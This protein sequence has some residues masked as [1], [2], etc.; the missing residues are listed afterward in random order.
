MAIIETHNLAKRYGS[1]WGI[2]DVDLSVEAGSIFGFL[3]PNGAGKTTT[4]R[5]LLGF[6]RPTSGDAH[7]LGKDCWTESASIKRDVGYLAGDVRL[8]SW[9]DARA[10]LDIVGKIR[11]IDLSAA[12]AALLDRFQLDPTVKVRRMSRGMRQKL[13]L[14]LCLAPKPRVLILDEP[15]SGLDPLMQD[16]LYDTLRE[17]AAS[18][19]T[20]LFS[21]HT[22]DEVERLCD[23]IAIVRSGNIVASDSVDALRQHAKRPVVIEFADDVTVA[24]VT[25]PPGLQLVRAYGSTI[26]A[27]LEGAA[28]RLLAWLGTQ[29]VVDITIGKA[30]LDSV[31]RS[32]YV[33]AGASV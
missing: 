3:G 8:Y 24:D 9:M 32:Y 19:A 11:Q 1:R 16:A 6:L 5:V 23:R 26:E 4:I 21:S 31:F 20:V 17:A 30:N 28:D 29:K 12:G 14:I 27:D 25:L 2:R 13:G 10:A 33:D 15:T 22:L 18:G 7:V